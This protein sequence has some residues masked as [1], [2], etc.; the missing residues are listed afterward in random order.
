MNIRALASQ[1]IRYLPSQVISP[2]AQLVSVLLL[3]HTTNA[4]SVGVVTLVTA[5]QELIFTVCLAWW[6]HYVMRHLQQNDEE[7]AVRIRAATG[8]MALC[9]VPLQVCLGLAFLFGNI[10]PQA[11]IELAVV[12]AIFFVCRGNNALNAGIA[13]TEARIL[14]FTIYT[15]SGPLG[16]L[17]VGT[18]L[19]VLIAPE[20]VWALAGYA[21][22]EAFALAWHRVR[23]TSVKV[24]F[25][26]S[27]LLAG[28]RF[29]A[30]LVAS[31]VLT[32]AAANA[33]RFVVNSELG[34]TAAGLFAVGYGLGMRAS[35]M[36]GSL[37]TAAAL[38]L[39]IREQNLGG[40]A[41]GRSQLRANAVLL[42]AV[43]IPALVGLLAVSGD[44]VRLAVA[45]DFQAGTMQVLPLSVVAGGISAFLSNCV[46][47]AFL[48]SKRTS[49]S[50]L[51]SALDA[52]LSIGLGFFL[53]SQ[54]GLLG[55]AAA[56]AVS[57]GLLLIAA[58]ALASRDYRF[59]VPITRIV[60]IGAST[61]VMYFAL[62]L[63]PSEASWPVVALK[64]ATGASIYLICMAAAHYRDLSGILRP[65]LL[66]MVK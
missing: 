29:G 30:P 20:P 41:G 4:M 18:A 39:A 22:G 33:S 2:L 9:A 42:L 60:S 23:A 54:Y 16:G 38:P 26:P 32:W 57:K 49:R 21:I 40:D 8:L 36:T 14:D 13:A 31:G 10:D 17:T 64:V 28:V 45:G 56:M 1:T 59:S 11:P 51:L 50:V 12:C 66:G 43:L 35:T 19:T 52:C 24:Q 53:T 44:V 5:T 27:L 46:N 55:A 65:K 6:M 58:M 61:C 15:I 63:F 3:T 25:D 7:H 37:V 62:R 34:I 48:L 47:H